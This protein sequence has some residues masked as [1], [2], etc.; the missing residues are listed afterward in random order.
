MPFSQIVSKFEKG[1]F[2]SKLDLQHQ[3]LISDAN[4]GTNSFLLSDICTKC[5]FVAHVWG[6]MSLE[7]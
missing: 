7:T 4:F 5:T 3:L 1:N 2:L 6:K